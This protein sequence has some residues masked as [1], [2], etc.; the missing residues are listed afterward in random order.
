MK[1]ALLA[2][3]LVLALIFAAFGMAED[4]DD[5]YEDAWVLCQPDSYINIRTFANKRS[6]V[7]GYLYSGDHVLLDGATKNGYYHVIVGVEAGEGWIKKGY[8]IRSKPE[9]DGHVYPISA[10]GR[11]AARRTVNGTRRRW[12][13]DGDEV[14]VYMRSEEWCL[15]NQGFIITECIDLESRM[16]IDQMSDPEDMTWEDE[17]A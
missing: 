5:R 6:E 16:D 10:N 11:V 8:V 1:K 14:K 3:T 17:A 9:R 7:A 2:L 12:M 13:H 15:T 4:Y